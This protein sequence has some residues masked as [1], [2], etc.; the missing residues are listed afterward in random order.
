MFVKNYLIS[1]SKVT[2]VK[3]TE[4]VKSA[5]SVMEEN[6]HDALPVLGDNNAVVGLISKQ[7]V[8]KVFFMQGGDKE[9]F[10]NNT[11]VQKLMKVN[12]KSVNEEDLIEDAIRQMANM[13]MQFIV[14]NKKNKGFAGIL[15]RRN[16]LDGMANA[17][18][19]DKKGVRVEVVINDAEGRLAAL[20]KVV[21]KYGYNIRSI[22]MT[23]PEVMNLRKIV[24]R[25]DTRDEKR[26][27]DMLV[28][29]GF[30]VLTS[31]LE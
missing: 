28:D 17:L 30:K 19:M 15:T 21:A 1:A 9:Q 4:S 11:P 27:V 2:T 29:A 22:F 5:L 18:G 26:V 20:T 3:E 25:L 24:L 7:H 23:D 6:S 10:I 13:R 12:F 14:V 31:V 16:L 8:Y